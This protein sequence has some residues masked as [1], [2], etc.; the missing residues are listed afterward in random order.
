MTKWHCKLVWY[1][2]FRGPEKERVHVYAW[3]KER[4]RERERVPE[5]WVLFVTWVHGDSKHRAIWR[6]WIWG[7]VKTAWYLYS[8]LADFQWRDSHRFYEGPKTNRFA[9]LNFQWTPQGKNWNLWFRLLGSFLFCYFSILALPKQFWYCQ[10][11]Q[12]I[13]L[14]QYVSKLSRLMLSCFRAT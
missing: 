7:A 6:S 4:E 10:F 12:A 1:I 8:K 3:A 11:P 13:L 5:L 9:C 2:V 14:F